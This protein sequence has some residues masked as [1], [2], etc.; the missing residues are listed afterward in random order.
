MILPGKFF[1]YLAANRPI[2]CIGAEGDA[3]EILQ[4]TGTGLFSS[5]EDEAALKSNIL[6]YYT[7]YSQGNLNVTSKGTERFS[8]EKLTGKITGILDSMISENI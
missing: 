3:S 8:R 2:L 6:T 7:S 1:E 4:E 5:F